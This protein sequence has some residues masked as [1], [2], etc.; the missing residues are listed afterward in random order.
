MTQCRPGLCDR[1]N[2]C[3][4]TLCPG[5]P[6]NEVEATDYTDPTVRLILAAYIAFV[7][8]CALVVASADGIWYFLNT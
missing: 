7:I 4:D 3:N 1:L 6:C 5:H 8:L 2:T